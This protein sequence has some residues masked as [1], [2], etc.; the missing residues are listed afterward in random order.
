ALVGLILIVGWLGGGRL[1]GDEHNA[2]HFLKDG[3]WD[4]MK[5]FHYG[6]TLKAQ[7]WVIHALFGN[8]FFWYRIPAAVAIACFVVWLAF[9]RKDGLPVDRVTQALVVLFVI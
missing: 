2:I 3:F 5:S 6:H 7:V 4:Y 9:F 1:V 8:S